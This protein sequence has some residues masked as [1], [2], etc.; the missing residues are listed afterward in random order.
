MTPPPVS[1]TLTPMQRRW[2]SLRSMQENQCVY[3]LCEFAKVR[4]LLPILM[5]RRNGERWTK[6]ER[7]ILLS[8]LRALS[9]LSPYLIPL[10]MP[11]GFLLLPILAWWLDRR[12]R[13]RKD[14]DSR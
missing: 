14:K 8:N 9:N 12:R 10:V 2:T 3:I 6:E 11:G 4:G 13:C 7:A 5:K 1:K